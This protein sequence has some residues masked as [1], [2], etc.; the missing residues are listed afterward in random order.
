MQDA[1]EERR[2]RWRQA[3]NDFRTALWGQYHSNL[4]E[5]LYHY[6]SAKGTRG[7]LSHKEIWLSDIRSMSDQRDGLYWIDVFR[8][9]IRRKSIP[10]YIRRGF[11][12]VEG[13]GIGQL[14]T[15]YIT[16]FSPHPDSEYQWG[17]YAD[18]GRGCAIEIS[19]ERLVTRADGGGSYGFMRMLYDRREQEEKAERTINRAIQFVREQDMNRSEAEE[20]WM[21]Y[22]AFDFLVCGLC[23]KHPEYHR[24]EEWRVFKSSKDFRND[25]VRLCKGRTIR[26][27]SL[28]LE[29]D[30]VTGL[31]KGTLCSESDAD[32]AELLTSGENKPSIRRAPHAES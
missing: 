23:F 16:C 26:Y 15:K 9:I 27:L 6:T 17:H 32:L 20:Y 12:T 3:D 29:P 7:I 24:E 11:E 18:G 31:F 13:L 2:A 30:M 21:G 25:P 4:P 14:W 1:T 8:P 10:G 19:V 28:A 22:A 5:R